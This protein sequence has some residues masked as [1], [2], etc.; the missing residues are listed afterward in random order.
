MWTN[1]H[2]R[3]FIG[4][5]PSSSFKCWSSVAHLA[6]KLLLGVWHN[7]CRHWETPRTQIAINWQENLIQWWRI[8]YS[9]SEY[10]EIW[11]SPE[12]LILC[13]WTHWY[14]LLNMLQ[15]NTSFSDW[16][17]DSV[18]VAKFFVYVTLTKERFHLSPEASYGQCLFQMHVTTWHVE[19]SWGL[20]NINP[21]SS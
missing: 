10:S 7:H 13:S 3:L 18:E 21:Q 8:I 20:A 6:Q 9:C 12:E 5:A 4:V 11:P 2:V 19:T 17:N 15:E 1:L 16:K 14:N